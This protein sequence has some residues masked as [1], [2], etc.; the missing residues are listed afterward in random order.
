MTKVSSFALQNTPALQVSVH[1]YLKDG[2]EDVNE[3][4]KETELLLS[5]LACVISLTVLKALLPNLFSRYD[6]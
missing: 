2:K 6:F 1:S 4:A 5:Y 3:E